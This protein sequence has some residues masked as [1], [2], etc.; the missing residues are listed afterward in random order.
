MIKPLRLFRRRLRPALGERLLP[1][2]AMALL[3]AMW[4]AMYYQVGLERE[5]AHGKAVSQSQAQARALSDYV[6]NILRQAGHATHLYQLKHLET[7]GAFPLT[8]FAR[9]G[10]L[11][12]SV[13]P[14]RL[15]V[16]MAVYDARGELAASLNRPAP[17][18]VAR[19]P[20]FATL[21][22][23]RAVAE[24]V[25]TARD[26]RQGSEWH[27]QVARRLA[28]PD[29]SFAG[30]IVMAIDPALFVDDYDRLDIDDRSAVILMSQAT[31]LSAGRLGE[32]MFTSD[33]LDFKVAG[34]KARRLA[35]VVPGQ[36]LD[37][38]DRIYAASEMP[39][40]S[41]PARRTTTTPS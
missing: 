17:A 25:T 16:P 4:G 37:E 2:F 20:W 38:I 7:R 11:L 29:G 33:T 30:A 36:Q 34:P 8:E 40:W 19:S 13:L 5:V 21:A 32:S 22:A 3:A 9:P 41:S 27:L 18:S 23:S 15:A 12:D 35:E 14:V 39:R 6:G 10:G 24:L 31:G 26:A 1:L 28:A